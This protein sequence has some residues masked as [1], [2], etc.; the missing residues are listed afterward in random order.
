[1][2]QV[3]KFKKKKKGKRAVNE[4]RIWRHKNN[5]EWEDRVSSDKNENKG[6]HMGTDAFCPSKIETVM[7]WVVLKITG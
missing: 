6:I 2:H 1:M 4:I 3:I 5:F 7:Q